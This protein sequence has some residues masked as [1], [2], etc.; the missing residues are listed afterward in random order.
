GDRI[1]YYSTERGD[2][3]EIPKELVD[4]DKTERQRKE[5]TEA[6]AKEAQEQDEEEKAQREQRREIAAIPI[7]VGAYYQDGQQV[8]TLKLADYQVVTN[9]KRRTLQVLSPVPLIPGKA[10]VV[11]QGDHSSFLVHDDRPAFYMRLAKQERFGIISLA[12]K[13]NFRVVE[14][15][16]IEP[17]V[18]IAIEDKKQL[19]T[20]Q[21]EL[22]PGL[23]RVWPEKPLTPGEYA[24]VEY[25]D[26]E[27]KDDI[28]LLV[29]DFALHP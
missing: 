20:F 3:E 13:K 19:D 24:L 9:K 15:I 7:D 17:V 5:K 10:S 27:S 18:K 4:L 2:W 12:P 25:E 14:N 8:K 6:L 22:A 16:A 28:E 26:T 1:R 29:W 23:Y 21:Q 11:I